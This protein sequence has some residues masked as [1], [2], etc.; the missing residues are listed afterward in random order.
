MH[1]VDIAIHSYM[2]AHIHVYTPIQYSFVVYVPWGCR[3]RTVVIHGCWLRELGVVWAHVMDIH[4][5]AYW[6]I[7]G[8]GV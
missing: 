5:E 2:H 4:S 3:V 6:L 8:Q 7:F 1:N